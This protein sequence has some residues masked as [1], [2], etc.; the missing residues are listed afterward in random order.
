LDLSFNRT[1]WSFSS[2]VFKKCRITLIC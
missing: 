2:T 1:R